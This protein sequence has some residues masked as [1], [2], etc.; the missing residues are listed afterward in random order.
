[1]SRIENGEREKHALISA[2]SRRLDRPAI[3]SVPRKPNSLSLSSVGKKGAD[4]AL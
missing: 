2:E 3:P 1:M 4:D